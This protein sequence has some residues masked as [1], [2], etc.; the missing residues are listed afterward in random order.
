MVPSGFRRFGHLSF[1]NQFSKTKHRMASEASNS[2]KIQPDISWF[3]YY[4]YYDSTKT[5][6]SKHQNKAEFKNLDNS[7]VF[8]SDFQTLETSAASLTSSASAA[9][10][11]STDS[12]VIFPKIFL[13]LMVWSSLAHTSPFLE[14]KSWKIQFL[15]DIWGPFCQR[16]LRLAYVTFFWKLVNE[17]LKLKCPKLLIGTLSYQNSQIYYP[18]EPLSFHHFTMRH[19]VV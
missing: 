5:F 7:E 14:N 2:A 11:A 15:T 18:S 9:S 6:F 8:S 10:L 1:I 3:Y 16:L 17:T 13:I 19:P 12:I 4:Y